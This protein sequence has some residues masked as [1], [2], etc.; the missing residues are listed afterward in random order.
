MHPLDARDAITG[1]ETLD[2]VS[3]GDHIA[4]NFMAEN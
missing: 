3:D 4:R 2:G 1:P